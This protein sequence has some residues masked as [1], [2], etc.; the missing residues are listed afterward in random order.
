VT[1]VVSVRLLSVSRPRDCDAGALTDLHPHEKVI[2]ATEKGG[3]VGKVLAPP[4]LVAQTSARK[5]LPP[6]R[7]LSRADEEKL[8]SNR[9]LERE[10]FAYAVERIE[11]LGLLM[12]LVRV[13]FAI[14]ADRATFYFSADQRVDF[15]RLV[16]DLAQRY[17]A[18]VLLEQVG[19]RD[20]ARMAGGVGPCGR[21]TCCTSWLG[22]TPSVSM[23]L[24]KRHYP[25]SNPA[26]LT[27]LCGRLRC[28]LVYE[29]TGRG[30][31]CPHREEGPDSGRQDL[32]E[33][34]GA[35][36]PSLGPLVPDR[37][38]D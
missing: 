36:D 3:L 35:P 31:P 10:A 26:K 34:L 32:S 24:L 27:G 8:A 21:E 7:R 29:L 22:E 16:R 6:V 2:A 13:E 5:P 12:K 18:R 38:L 17:H 25:N 30:T 33:A 37:R 20:A 15:R 28:C 4:R 11:A 9:L 23:A 19:A 1:R 14:E